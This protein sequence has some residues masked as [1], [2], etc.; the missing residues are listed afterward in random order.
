MAPRLLMKTLIKLI[1]VAL[2]LN[3]AYRVG[4][5]YWTHYQ[6]QDSIQEMAQFSEHAAPEE[7]R[8]RRFW[9]WLG[10]LG[11]PI[12]PENLTV[13]RGNRRID[14][15]GQLLQEISRSCR[16]SRVGGTSRFMSPC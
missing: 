2:V 16:A 13:T 14:I 5:A 1:I 9:S 15:D 6:F 12:E 11:V 10:R 7:L 8:T 3:A 4:S